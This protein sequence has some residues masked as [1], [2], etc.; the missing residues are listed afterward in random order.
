MIINRE[1]IVSLRLQI[2]IL[3][4]VCE[5]CEAERQHKS[6]TNPPLNLPGGPPAL[7]SRHR[8]WL[9]GHKGVNPVWPETVLPGI[10]V[11]S[12]IR[13]FKQSLNLMLYNQKSVNQQKNHKYCRNVEYSMFSSTWSFG[14]NLNTS[15]IY[16]IYAHICKVFFVFLNLEEKP[17]E[18]RTGVR[19][20][21]F[22]FDVRQAVEE[23]E[24]ESSN[25]LKPLATDKQGLLC[26]LPTNMQG[27]SSP[28]ITAILK[29]IH[30]KI[31]DK[32]QMKI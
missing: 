6:L 20:H 28:H 22:D 10:P 21:V 32:T 9:P 30:D 17:L 11:R 14:L 25:R 24:R 23:H 31:W 16:D 3:G 19:A 4:L 27:S 5:A 7:E 12:V 1:T 29:P 26:F 8:N 13:N 18:G 2:K 15:R